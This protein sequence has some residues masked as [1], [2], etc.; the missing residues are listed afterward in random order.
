MELFLKKYKNQNDL[1]SIK[2][3]YF[4]SLISS[5]DVSLPEDV[6]RNMTIMI[7]NAPCN[8]FGDVVFGMKLYNYI[9]EWY[10]CNVVLAT[11]QPDNFAKLGVKSSNIVL[12]KSKIKNSQCRR[13][14]RMGFY[15]P[16]TGKA[17]ET[18]PADLILVAP[19]T[20]DMEP[21]Y[22]DVRKLCGYSTRMNTYFFSE[23]NDELEK[24]FDF[25]T[26]IGEGR[27][28]LLFTHV[29]NEAVLPPLEKTKDP[30]TVMYVATGRYKRKLE[31]CYKSF[32]K[33]VCSDK[34]YHFDRFDVYTNEYIAEQI[35]K[36]RD[37]RKY[38]PKAAYSRVEIITSKGVKTLGEKTGP[39]IRIRSDLFPLPYESMQRLYQNSIDLVLI[40]GDQSLTDVIS[41]CHNSSYPFYQIMPWKMDLAVNLA[42]KLDQ[43]YYKE[44]ETSCGSIKALKFKP[45]FKKFVKENDFRVNAK[46]KID[47]ML[48]QRF[49]CDEDVIHVRCAIETARTVQEIKSIITEV[50]QK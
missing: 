41:C 39:V 48:Y 2:D 7:L 36:D 17:L 4:K 49:T 43:K 37:Y 42:K 50:F 24:N 18:P 3:L 14:A 1:Y 19:V 38:I 40:T 11:T 45:N 16:S 26:G 28:G 23:Y 21:D 15:D 35:Y 9:K 22:A 10:G 12:L 44:Y 27:L 8:G 30:Y 29:E 13:F 47:A 33:M 46:P 34:K 5:G 25:H 20:T 31:M 6:K 32:L